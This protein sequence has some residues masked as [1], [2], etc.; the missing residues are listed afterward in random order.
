MGSADY[1]TAAWAFYR[2]KPSLAGAI[3]FILLFLGSTVVHTYQLYKT[4]SLFFIPFLIGGFCKSFIS[5]A[6]LLSPFD[7]NDTVEWIGYIGRAA[8]SSQ[9]PNW[10]LGPYIVQ[11]LL[12]LLAPA[13]F[14]ASIYMLL[15]RIILV[16]QA[17][18]H[19]LIKKRWLTK[20][21]VLGDVLSFLLQSNGM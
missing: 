21:F 8:S 1:E 18:K 9:T 2:Y 7:N 11:S 10:T 4:R 19:S 16:L 12:L 14:A 3:I 20:T 13:L 6:N 5:A 17:E 15:G